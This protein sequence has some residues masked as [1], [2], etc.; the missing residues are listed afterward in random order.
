LFT[1]IN[2]LGHEILLSNCHIGHKTCLKAQNI[3]LLHLAATISLSIFHCFNR[4]YGFST[5]NSKKK[6]KT[7]QTPGSSMWLHTPQACVQAAQKA[8]KAELCCGVQKTKKKQQTIFLPTPG[9]YAG[10]REQ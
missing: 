5:L 1:Q 8:I 4:Q 6:K 10:Q 3:T 7:T 9:D 2:I